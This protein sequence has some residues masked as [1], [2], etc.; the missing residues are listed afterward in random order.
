M[1]QTVNVKVADDLCTGCGAC[2]NSCPVNA[3]VMGA[4]SEGFSYPEVN[5]DNCIE[6]GKCLNVCPVLSYKNSNNP[7]PKIYAVRAEDEVRAV[8]SSGGVFSVLAE[9]VLDANGVVCGAAFDKEMCLHHILIDNKKELYKLRGSKYLQSDVG[10]IY[11]E[12]E[13]VLKEGRKVL[14]TGTPCQNAALRNILTKEYDN[15]LLVDIIC[16]G[17]PSQKIFF[18]STYRKLREIKKSG[19]LISAVKSSVGSQ[20]KY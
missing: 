7:K 11:K 2:V 18:Q 6:C 17:V 12:I 1:K 19:T 14:F 10:T 20:G 8:S 9:A 3:I 5:E 4:D 16:H 13:E 15:L